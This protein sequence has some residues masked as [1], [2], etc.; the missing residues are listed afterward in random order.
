MLK[1]RHIKRNKKTKTIYI[2][3]ILTLI[4][5]AGGYSLLSSQLSLTGTAKGPIQNKLDHQINIYS[6]PWY[7]QIVT[8]HANLTRSS[9]T[10][11]GGNTLT[12]VYNSVS[13]NTSRTL[14]TRFTYTNLNYYTL[15]GGTIARTTTCTGITYNSN[16]LS[17]TT[18]ARNATVT[19][20]TSI[21]LRTR[22]S[23]NCTITY[24]ITYTYGGVAKT[25]KYI[26]DI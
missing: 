7:V 9:E 11:T 16:T 5:L 6:S 17:T 26:I 15:T 22:T 21:S 13:N 23:N 4:F 18:L 24:T 14:A 3:A 1:H 20:N 12:T 19:V 2:L 8:A 10:V 25:L